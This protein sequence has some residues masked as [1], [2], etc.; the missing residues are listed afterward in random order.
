M[1]KRVARIGI[2]AVSR[3]ESIDVLLDT[4]EALGWIGGKTLD[5]MFPDP[6]SEDATLARN[7][8]HIVATGVDLVVAQTRSAVLI[9]ANAAGTVP[10]VMGAFNGDP[11]EEGIVRSFE[12][13]GGN[14]TGTYYRGQTGGAQRLALLK[15]L[16]PDARRI[17]VLM[18]PQNRASMELAENLAATAR[19]M[20][21]SATLFGAR[22]C[23]EID[24]AFEAAADTGVQ[25]VVTVTGADMYSFR[26]DI[27][28]AQSKH[29]L[30]AIMGSIGFPELGGL[31]KL[32]PDIPVLWKKMAAAHVDPIL[33]GARPGDLPLVGLEDF[34]LVINLRTAQRLGISVPDAV[35]RRASKL[36]E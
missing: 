25:A 24:G 13:P 8:R 17:G 18:N 31:A 34:E 10:V 23:T 5:V 16:I 9:A 22:V 2:L 4:L 29:R 21:L 35:K 12:R 15:E 19:A 6:S 32:G 14:V 26:K 30:P 27:V 33:K 1:V 7:L 11:V 3:A 20:D 28:A 36:L